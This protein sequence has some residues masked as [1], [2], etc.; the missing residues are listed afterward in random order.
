M[1]HFVVYFCFWTLTHFSLAGV[2]VVWMM[3]SSGTE[4]TIHYF[5]NFVKS[6]SLEIKPVII[7]SDHDQAQMNAI[8]AAYPDSQLLLCRWH[9]LRA[10]QMHFCTEEF[11]ALWEWV[12]KW[13]K[14]PD[15]LKFDSVWQWIQTD[16]SV[17]QSFVDYLKHNWMP[18]VSLWAGISRLDW[19]IF[20]EN[21]TNMLI[22]A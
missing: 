1:V 19:T 8:K 3:S 15:Q 6:H 14:M 4:M 21:D 9:V 2:P 11:P 13:V 17:P 5:L 16:C 20:E 12:C 7:M 10:M 22:K 18:I